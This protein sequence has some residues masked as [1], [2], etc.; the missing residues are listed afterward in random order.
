MYNFVMTKKQAMAILDYKSLLARY[1]PGENKQHGFQQQVEKQEDPH[2]HA[3][4]QNSK[5]SSPLQNAKFN[6]Q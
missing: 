4:V 3:K 1:A 2:M 5:P 6:P